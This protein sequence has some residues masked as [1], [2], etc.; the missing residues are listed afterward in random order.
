[1]LRH[2]PRVSSFPPWR[3]AV[4]AGCIASLALACGGKAN[5]NVFDDDG[6]SGGTSSDGS[7]G[8]TADGSGGTAGGSSS[9]GN[10]T[11]DSGDSGDSGGSGGTQGTS[12]SGSSS[13]GST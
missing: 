9:N 13:D 10:G 11:G 6:G 8:T 12:D 7:G 1:M 2:T 5:S 4:L 3:A